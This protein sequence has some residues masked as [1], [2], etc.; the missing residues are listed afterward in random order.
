MSLFEETVAR[1]GGLDR[2]AMKEA[3]DMYEKAQKQAEEM[4]EKA[5]EDASIW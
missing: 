4:Y 1:I 2:R 5:L 3:S